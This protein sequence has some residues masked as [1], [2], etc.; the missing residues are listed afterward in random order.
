VSFLVSDFL[1]AGYEKSLRIAHQRH[2][3]I[4]ICI[5]DRRELSIPP[6][7]FMALQDL[8]TGAYVVVDTASAAVRTHYARRRAAAV[9]QRQQVFRT[10]GIDAIEVRT[11]APYM[12]PLLRFF[13][14]RERS[15]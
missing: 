2:D 10:L 14:K 12:P 13:H 4:P 5:T 3:I 8:E 9:A 7:G 6:L 1:A 11:D 15:R